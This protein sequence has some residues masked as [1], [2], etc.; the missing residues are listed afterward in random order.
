M[1]GHVV[2]EWKYVGFPSGMIDPKINDGVRGDIFVQFLDKGNDIYSRLFN[3]FEVAELAW[4]GGI[5]WKWGSNTAAG[6]ARQNHDW[7][8]LANGDMLLLVSL[9]HPDRRFG[10]GVVHDQ[11]IYEID[12]SGTIVWRWLAADHLKEMG[13]SKAGLDLVYSGHSTGDAGGGLLTINSMKILGPN[14]W[15]AHGDRRFAPDNIL[16]GS[17]EGDFLAIIDTRTGHLVWRMGPYYPKYPDGP[18]LR[19][20][21]SR[22]PRAVDGLVG[23][24]DPNMIAEGLLGA[25]DILVLDNEGSAGYPPAVMGMFQGSRVL[26]INPVTRQIVWQ[27]SA[28]NSNQMIW[29]FDTSFMGDARRLPNGNTFVCEA[30]NGR[31]FQITPTGRIVWEYVNPHFAQASVGGRLLMTDSTYRAQ[32]VPYD[33]VPAGTPHS[34]KAVIPP[35]ISS[36]HLR[37]SN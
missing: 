36:W 26:E 37:E 17:R 31:F 34:E 23:Q 18:S 21:D 14:R 13:F 4:N 25:G 33:W 28:E 24:H 30:M 35:D 10:G 8:R 12:K 15:Y 22:L 16:I 1:D 20:F 27:Y 32:P 3:N 7:A 11:A 6:A 29:T 2:H 9:D 19:V 5:V